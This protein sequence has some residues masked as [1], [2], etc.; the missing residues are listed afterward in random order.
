MNDNKKPG[1]ISL[2]PIG[3]ARTP[4]DESFTPKQPLRREAEPGSFRIVIDEAY[5]EGLAELDKCSHI[6]VLAYMDQAEG[7]I[8]L[9]VHPPLDLG[10][11][12]GVFAARS[13]NRPNHIG[14]SVV[15]LL[16][17]EGCEIFISPIDLYDRTPILDIKP[18]FRSLDA[19]SDANDGW[20]EEVDG[21]EHA[22]EHLLGMPHEH[23]HDHH[24]HQDHQDHADEHSHEHEHTHDHHHPHGDD[25]K[26]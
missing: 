1:T 17:I 11:E 24:D 26:D 3:H 7:K 16:K 4:Y 9:R 12:V 25:H 10:R 23:G 19:R 8:N 18:Y 15:H 20:M 2:T 21:F 5:A 14:L 6:T 22:V 13:P